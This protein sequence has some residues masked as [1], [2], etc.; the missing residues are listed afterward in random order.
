[1]ADRRMK[2]AYLHDLK[3]IMSGHHMPKKVL[4]SV[5]GLEESRVSELVAA[6]HEPYLDEA[7]AIYRALGL[8]GIM[9]LIGSGYL[10]SFDM[11]IP[12]PTDLDML[13][14]GVRLPLSL[15][16]RIAVKI[17]LA[18]P[19]HIAGHS[20]TFE[21]WDIITT[22]RSTT[23]P[24]C[25]VPTVGDTLTV[26]DPSCLPSLLWGSRDRRPYA[27]IGAAP[28]PE[29]PGKGR[30]ASGWAKGA[31]RERIKVGMQAKEL[32][33]AIGKTPDYV[34]KI[35]CQRITL[36]T[37]MADTISNV[38]RCDPAQLYNPEPFSGQATGHIRK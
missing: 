8:H 32:A 35:E 37:A 22:L 31:R 15:A 1:M 20:V 12:L 14:A 27:E 9:P 11:G 23:C 7:I 34:S 19:A 16:C 3:Q 28:K 4:A 29:R 38:L 18:D 21:L 30:R 26:H 6:T 10:T 5:V 24:Y 33:D 13:R 25:H 17:G 36:T 2:A